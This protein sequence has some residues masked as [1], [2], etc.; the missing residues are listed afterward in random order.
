MNTQGKPQNQYQAYALSQGGSEVFN[1]YQHTR[2]VEWSHQ[3]VILALHSYESSGKHVHH[4]D[5][6]YDHLRRY[7]QLVNCLLLLRQIAARSALRLSNYSLLMAN[8]IFKPSRKQ[9]GTRFSKFNYG[10]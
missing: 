2:P 5:H 10:V 9:S 8:D 3:G 7:K 4:P 1:G 6:V